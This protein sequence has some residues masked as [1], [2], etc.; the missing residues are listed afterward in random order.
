[1]LSTMQAT[2]LEVNFCLSFHLIL[3]ILK[4][5]IAPENLWESS[6]EKINECNFQIVHVFKSLIQ[7][8]FAD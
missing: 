1:M 8:P 4:F 2:T 3:P 6:N 5:S 7:I